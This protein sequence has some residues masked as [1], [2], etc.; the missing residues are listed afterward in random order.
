MRMFIA[1]ELPGPFAGETEELA[2]RLEATCAGRFVPAENRHLTLAFLGE[3]GEADARLAMLALDAACA[4]AGPVPLVAAGL[5]TFGRG[6]DATL[7]LGVEKNDGLAGLAGRVRAEL[8]A[9]GLAYDEKDFLPHV[10]L[11]RRA[12]M[13]RGDLGDLAFPL[14]D[15]ARD[16][17]LFRSILGPSGARYKPLYTVGL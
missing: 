3:G 12:R 10:T 1:L 14:P 11:A 8:A 5:G 17:T 15:E 7:W 4:G 2:R 9:R 16:V 13:P 6:R